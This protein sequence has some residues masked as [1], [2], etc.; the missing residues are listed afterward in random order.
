[1]RLDR[2]SVLTLGEIERCLLVVRSIGAVGLGLD[3][4]GR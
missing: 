3:V 4:P 2:T 1:M